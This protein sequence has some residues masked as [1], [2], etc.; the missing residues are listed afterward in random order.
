M[1]RILRYTALLAI[2]FGSMALAGPAGAITQD[3]RCATNP[4]YCGDDGTTVGGV[5][6]NR[7][8]TAPQVRGIEVTRAQELPVTGG[9]IIGLVMVGLAGI[10]AGVAL[11]RTARSRRDTQSLA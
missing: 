1:K 8:T 11:T 5:D 6:Q 4:A 3:P 9:D 2:V 7:S 10:G